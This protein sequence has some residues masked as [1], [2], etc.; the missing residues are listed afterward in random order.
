[1]SR[2]KNI[3]PYTYCFCRRCAAHVELGRV[4]FGSSVTCPACGF[5]FAIEHPAH[6]RDG[7]GEG[8]GAGD[9]QALHDRLAPMAWE[10]AG[11]GSLTRLFF[12]GTLT[13]PLRLGN[14]GR[15]LTLCA[16]T[17]ALVGAFRLGVWCFQADDDQLDRSTRVLLANGLLFSVVFGSLVLP[18]WLYAAS[19]YGMTILRET[20]CGVDRIRDW[21][22]LLALEGLGEVFYVLNAALLSAVP[23][24]IAAWL[25]TRLALPA[26]LPNLLSSETGLP[27]T[28]LWVVGGM[29]LLF[30]ILLLSML[31]ADSPVH[32]LSASAWRTLLRQ[33]QA[34]LAFSMTAFVAAIAAVALAVALRHR[35]GWAAQV[36]VSGVLVAVGWMIY[37]RLLGRLAS[38]C[39]HHPQDGTSDTGPTKGDRL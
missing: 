3:V 22:H 30:P 37:C 24:K 23:G 35:A 13:F 33:W 8:R 26:T 18:A 16:G 6:N 15:T 7:A 31:A 29:M 19:C 14:L 10:A 17:V 34:W 25:W 5:E 4:A 1:M 36:I 21:P 39:A 2:D 28:G 32:P 11:G 20:A 9:Q 27:P 38:S 12:A